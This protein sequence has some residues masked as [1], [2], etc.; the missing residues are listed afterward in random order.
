[1]EI[2]GHV[3][4]IVAYPSENKPILF[5]VKDQKEQSHLCSFLGFLPLREKDNIKAI[6]EKINDVL[7]IKDKPLVVIPSN[8]DYIKDCLYKAL[9]K[10]KK[11]IPFHQE[12]YKEYQDEKIIDQIE[13]WVLHRA[14]RPEFE[15]FSKSQ[16]NKFLLWWGRHISKRRLYLLGLFDKEI[17]DSKLDDYL[18]YTKLKENPYKI[19]TLSIEKAN[20]INHLMG[21]ERDDRD[22][23]SAKIVR[24]I[25]QQMGKGWSA[26]PLSY[27]HQMYPEIINHA[28]YL[29][30]DFNLVFEEELVYNNYCHETETFLAKKICRL[31]ERNNDEYLRRKMMPGN[32]SPHRK[33]EEDITLTEE[34]DRALKGA[35]ENHIS[36]ITGGAGCGKTTMIRQIINNLIFK[37]KEFV[38][39]AFTGKAVLKIK[40]TLGREL[41]ENCMTMSRMIHKK[42]NHQEVPKF[43]ILIVDEAGM[44]SSSLIYQF[45]TYFRHYFRIILIGDANQLPPIGSGH[46]FTQLINC[47]RIPVYYLTI[48]KRMVMKGD[49]SYILENANNLISGKEFEYKTGH[50]FEIIQG[51]MKECK[52]VINALKKK[53]IQ[54][55]DIT[56][57]TPFNRDIPEL[58]KEHQR[59]YLK[60]REIYSYLNCDYII[61]DRI[62][63]TKNIYNE[64]QEVMNGEEGIITD[65]NKEGLEVQFS[66]EKKIFYKWAQPEDEKKIR[67]MKEDIEDN[68][69]KEFLSSDLKHSFC[70]TVHKSQGSEYNYVIFYLPPSRND[71]I[72]INL[73]YTAITRAKKNLWIVGCK[74]SLIEGSHKKKLSY[75]EK[76][77][78]RIESQI[79]VPRDDA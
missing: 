3:T 73:I 4:K 70:K 25:S 45:L 31:V 15:T 26:V 54:D 72:N 12:L 64:D 60:G 52:A 78:K 58:I 8:W 62:M 36:I 10:N 34:Q 65:I 9:P 69:E 44:V 13:D 71:F 50:G 37:K 2:L 79:T 43:D 40:E 23:I 39:T 49:K 57:L 32:H 11:I 63:Q 18:L 20:E 17:K 30:K 5:R 51:G 68:L 22:F 67:V 29:E 75:Y 19:D 7:V 61:G 42:M 59:C 1:M 55:S 41:E 47:Q 33:F 48:N 46:F 14:H 28:A 21:R 76:L 77:A 53:G 35:L 24:T 38:L 27:L 16:L 56:I 66:P 74:Q 6:G